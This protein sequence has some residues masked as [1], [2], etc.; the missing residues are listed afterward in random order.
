MAKSCTRQLKSLTRA[1]CFK[2]F[3]H[4]TVCSGAPLEWVRWVR[5]HPLKSGNGCAVPVLR[6]QSLSWVYP[7]SKKN[8]IFVANASKSLFSPDFF[9]HMYFWEAKTVE[10]TLKLTIFEDFVLKNCILGVPLPQSCTR[11]VIAPA[12]PLVFQSKPTFWPFMKQ[13][14]YNL[15]TQNPKPFFSFYLY[16]YYLD[17]S[18]EVLYV[19]LE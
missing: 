6:T 2:V 4:I 3:Q 18:K 19:L 1:L 10:N 11:P 7:S 15:T 9:I 16:E 14:K 17:L 13:C 12:A 5:P 8:A